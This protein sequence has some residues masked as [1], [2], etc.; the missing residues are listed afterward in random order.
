MSSTSWWIKIV[1]GSDP[2]AGGAWMRVDRSLKGLR[3][4]DLDKAGLAPP[5]HFIVAYEERN[6]R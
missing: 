2:N 4:A 5:G 3:F 1:P 6:D